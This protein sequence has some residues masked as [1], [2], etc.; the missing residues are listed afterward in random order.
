MSGN[1]CVLF[2]FAQAVTYEKAGLLGII[3][4]F[5]SQAS[6]VVIKLTLTK[7]EK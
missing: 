4:V 7:Q 2:T 1:L 5:T 6:V 3:A